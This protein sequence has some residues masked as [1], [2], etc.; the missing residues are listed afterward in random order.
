MSSLRF[1]PGGARVQSFHTEQGPLLKYNRQLMQAV[2]H[3]RLNIA[4]IVN[5]QVISLEDAAK[6]YEGFDQG[7]A[8]N[9]ALDPHGLV[10]KAA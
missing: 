2:L 10:G 5:A 4:D 3:G 6:G 1:G 7:A 9:F 8:K